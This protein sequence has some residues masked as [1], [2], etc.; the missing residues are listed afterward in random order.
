M[1]TEPSDEQLMGSLA[2]GEARRGLVRIC[3][4]RRL[5]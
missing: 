3:G 2:A 1:E 5:G 4:R